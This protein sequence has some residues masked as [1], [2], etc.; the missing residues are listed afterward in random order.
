MGEKRLIDANALAERISK[1][2]GEIDS[3]TAFEYNESKEATKMTLDD[4]LS[5]VNK[6][7]TIDP[8]S[9][10]TVA[11][12]R[13]SY[14]FLGDENY[15]C[16]HCGEIL[17]LEDGTPEENEYKFCPFCGAKIEC[18]DRTEAEEE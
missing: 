17:G 16:T 11:R 18:V 1:W 10:R 9:L 5:L 14:S 15:T 13:M 8:E 7:P 6:A 4:V 3:E 12:W 2:I